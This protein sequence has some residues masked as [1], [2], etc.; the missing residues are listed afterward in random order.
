MQRMWVQSLVRKLRSH[1]QLLFSRSVYVQLFVTPWTCSVPGFPVL[2]YLPEFAQT[3]VHWVG[4]AIQASHPLSPPS[5]TLNLF[6]IRAFCSES[7]LHIRWLKYWIFNFNI[8]PSKEYTELISFRTD[9]FD[10]LVVQGT[11]KSLPEHHS[12]KVSILRCPTSWG[13]PKPLSHS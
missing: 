11:L 3:H 2:H 4:D 12:S 9:W 10:L 7:A 6:S 5:S 13:A 8:S 1:V